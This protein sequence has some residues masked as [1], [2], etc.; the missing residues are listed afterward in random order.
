MGVQERVLD[1]V[2]GLAG[3]RHAAREVVQRRPHR[4]TV[5]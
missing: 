5:P 1:D 3:S 4:A 2:L